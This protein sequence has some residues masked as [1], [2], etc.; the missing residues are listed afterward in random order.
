MDMLAYIIFWII[1]LVIAFVPLILGFIKFVNLSEQTAKRKRILIAMKNNSYTPRQS[2]IDDSL[3][4][5]IALP[6][7][8]DAFPATVFEDGKRKLYVSKKSK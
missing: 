6:V 7:R 2:K 8:K 1:G 5:I 4:N 3:E